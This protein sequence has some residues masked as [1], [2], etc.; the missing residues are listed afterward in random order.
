[1]ICLL[2]FFRNENRITELKPV[3][4]DNIPDK[5]EHGIIY[6]SQMYNIAIHLCVCGCNEKTVTPTKPMAGD[7]NWSLNINNG[8]ITLRPSIGNF[9]GENPYHAHYFITENK[10]KWCN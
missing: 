7:P 1:M 5:L 3:F 4:V 9:K 10:I 2:W 8:K 6:I